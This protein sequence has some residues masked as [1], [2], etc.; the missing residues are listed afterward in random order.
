MLFSLTKTIFSQGEAHYS[1]YMF[2]GLYVNPAYAGSRGGFSAVALYRHQWHGVENG[3]R[4]ANLSMHAPISNGLFSV[5]VHV[6]NDRLGVMIMNSA[7]ATFAVRFKLA[8]GANASRL[9]IGV[10]GGF[11]HFNINNREVNGTL[12]VND[13]AF[14]N[15]FS[16]IGINTGAGIYLDAPNYFVGFSMPYLLTNDIVYGNGTGEMTTKVDIKQMPMIASTGVIFNAGSAMK[17]K[18]SVF[19]KYQYAMP[20]DIDLTLGFHIKEV[21]FIGGT[22]RVNNAAIAMAAINLSNNLRVGYAYE[23]SLNNSLKSINTGT[24]EIML[25][26]DFMNKGTNSAKCNGKVINPRQFR[27]F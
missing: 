13:P 25:G 20:I 22:Y 7:F 4:S 5:G 11:K 12:P 8:Q 27:Y 3:P 18:P 19:V 1:Q 6:N 16:G 14:M 9:A 17:I 15:N 2:N 24:H 10:Q 21:F 23:L 26:I